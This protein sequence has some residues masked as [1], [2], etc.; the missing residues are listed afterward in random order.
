MARERHNWGET[1]LIIKLATI[2]S[3]RILYTVLVAKLTDEYM[4]K[5]KNTCGTKDN[6]RK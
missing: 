1:K 6:G 3:G 5:R 4:W 2:Q